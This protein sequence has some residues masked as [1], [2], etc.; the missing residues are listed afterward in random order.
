MAQKIQ[1]KKGIV[2]KGDVAIA[3]LEGEATFLKGTDITLK[4]MTDEPLLHVKSIILNYHSVFYES[5]NFYSFEFLSM[6][7]AGVITFDYTFSSERK[8]I[9]YLY[10]TIGNDFLNKSGLNE[11][12]VN[13]FLATKSEGAK[14]HADTTRTY[15]MINNERER[16]KRPV[17]SRKFDA[18]VTLQSE[19]VKFNSSG[20]V[21]LEM[22]NVYYDNM[23]IGKISKSIKTGFTAPGATSPGEKTSLYVAERKVEPFVVDGERF[24]FANMAR[25]SFTPNFPPSISAYCERAWAKDIK[26]PD[27]LSAEKQIATWLLDKGCW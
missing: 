22:F 17:E 27:I 26:I 10:E 21:S 19:G 3:K 7:K 2:S 15:A 12:Q 13:S 14:I 18:V 1:V 5:M 9:E 6:K 16:L 11:E 4:S 8:L 24:E 25:F 20:N 23:L